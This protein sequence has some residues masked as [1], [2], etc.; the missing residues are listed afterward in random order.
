MRAIFLDIARERT[1]VPA[2]R[3]HVAKAAAGLDHVRRHAEHI[4]ELL[5]EDHNPFGRIVEDQALGHVVDGGIEPLFF[6]R[7]QFLRLQ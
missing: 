6:D 1:G 2:V 7:F 4:D 3:D 5:V